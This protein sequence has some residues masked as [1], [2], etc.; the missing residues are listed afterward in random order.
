MGDDVD[1]LGAGLLEDLDDRLLDL[2]SAGAD[3]ARGFLAAVENGRAVLDQFGGDSAPVIQ[4][5]GIPEEN[6]VDHEE[7]IFRLAQL[8]RFARF[9]AP[10]TLALILNFP[11]RDLHD[12]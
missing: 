6:A 2:E 8:E 4:V 9:V 10:V 12:P 11:A 1:L 7:R 5:L 3:V